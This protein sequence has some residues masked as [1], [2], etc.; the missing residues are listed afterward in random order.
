M[1][2]GYTFTKLLM[3]EFQSMSNSRPFTIALFLISKS[4]FP[5]QPFPCP[6]SCLPLCR[7]LFVSLD[8]T[9]LLLDTMVWNSITEGV[10]FIPH[11][12]FQHTVLVQNYC[13][14]LS[15][16]WGS[17][18]CPNYTTPHFLAS[19]LRWNGPFGLCLY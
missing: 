10:L 8:F 19:C 14:Q 4:Q 7:H 13:L 15:L 1:T 2:M 18:F 5:F 3:I 12:S 6:L 11:Y 17:L 9:F 16:S